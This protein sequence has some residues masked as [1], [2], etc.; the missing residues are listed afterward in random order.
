[1]QVYVSLSFLCIFGNT[2]WRVL[3]T[4]SPDD[5][6]HLYCAFG[7]ATELHSTDKYLPSII[8]TTFCDDVLNV[9]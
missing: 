4:I 6:V 7:L 9:G 3:E 1:M 8:D 2:K 5:E